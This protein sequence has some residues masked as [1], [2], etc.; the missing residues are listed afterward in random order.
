MILGV[1]VPRW[2]RQYTRA[3]PALVPSIC[4]SRNR[5][6][7]ASSTQGHAAQGAKQSTA[8]RAAFP[9]LP[10]TAEPMPPGLGDTVHAWGGHGLPG[11]VSEMGGRQ[12]HHGPSLLSR[13]KPVG[14]LGA[15]FGPHVRSSAAY[16]LPSCAA[17]V[18]QQASRGN[19]LSPTQVLRDAAKHTRLHKEPRAPPHRLYQNED[20][21]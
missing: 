14:P 13:R 3:S 9:S 12:F 2:A 7:V 11:R 6:P 18:S 1:A 10:A 20:Q 17:H 16:T 8:R 21:I 4:G 5:Q 19:D 15:A